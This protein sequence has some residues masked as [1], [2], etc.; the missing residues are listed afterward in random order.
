MFPPTRA[1][2]KVTSAAAY[3]KFATVSELID[4]DAW[5]GGAFGHTNEEEQK[6]AD[7][8]RELRE[9]KDSEDHGAAA[10]L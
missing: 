5:C 1:C 7:A 3:V 2:L 8:A 9:K 10:G 6:A 4:Y